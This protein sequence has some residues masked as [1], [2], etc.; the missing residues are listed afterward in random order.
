MAL[1]NKLVMA[2]HRS[3][4][5]QQDQKEHQ[6]LTKPNQISDTSEV[7]NEFDLPK[8]S[9]ENHDDDHYGNQKVL[10]LP[11]VSDTVLIECLF[12]RF[13]LISFFWLKLH[14]KHIKVEIENRLG[15]LQGQK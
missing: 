12:L 7:M 14:Y 11:R 6:P 13:S 15:S 4:K 9:A 3:T 5:K 2:A 8:T 10:A 1:L